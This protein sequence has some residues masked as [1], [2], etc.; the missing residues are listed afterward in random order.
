MKLDHYQKRL[1]VGWEDVFKRGLLTYWVLLS[2]VE[3]PRYAAEIM[4]FIEIQS[5]GNFAVEEQSLY[6]ALRRYVDSELVVY[7]SQQTSNG[8]DRKYY[9]LTT[10]GRKVLA[11]FIK[12]NISP[13]HN[14]LTIKLLAEGNSYE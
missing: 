3:Q 4:Q 14:E 5:G 9:E 2:L 8:A 10:T 13:L 11:V 6:R 1:L 12:Q 7:S